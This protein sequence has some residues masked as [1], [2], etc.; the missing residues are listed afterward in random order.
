MLG[1]W[2]A[3]ASAQPVQTCDQSP[4]ITI[5]VTADD[6][7]RAAS[8]VRVDMF[9]ELP[10]T[11]RAGDQIIVSIPHQLKFPA[12]TSYDVMASD[13]S[14]MGVMRVGAEYVTVTWNSWIETHSLKAS[15][16]AFLSASVTDQVEKG[17]TSL[18][19]NVQGTVLRTPINVAVCETECTGMPDR[20]GKWASQY[21]TDTIN[22][23]LVSPT[24]LRPGTVITWTDTVE[25]GQEIQCDSVA[26]AWYASRDPKTGWLRHGGKISPTITQ[27]DGQHVSAT[28]SGT[29]V[30]KVYGL[31]LQIRI[32]DPHREYWRDH[33][34]VTMDSESQSLEAKAYR[35]DGGAAGTGSTPASPT[36][37]P[38]S[39]TGT[40]TIPPVADS[41]GDAT[42]APT[43]SAEATAPEATASAT[44]TGTSKAD[45]T[46][47]PSGT[48][49]QSPTTLPVNSHSRV[50]VA[51]ARL[52]DTGFET[53]DTA[54]LGAGL[55]VVGAGLVAGSRIRPRPAPA[56]RRPCGPA[57]D[58]AP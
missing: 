5:C 11:T 56:S 32:T 16:K 26:G 13:G 6:P 45:E 30:G 31:L 57:A 14:V 33:G 47:T 21:T 1:P 23:G 53:T 18:T 49:A 9:G 10:R 51:T 38:A 42:I 54:L 15:W 27:C 50:P 17:A 36:P 29:E 35:Y 41:K 19:W 28:F 7:A 52:A 22:A 58:P 39:P 48:M 44:G 40:A 34:T 4:Q 37:S 2:T 25:D 43:E 3:S 8:T 24:V 46:G 20:A 55:L 12:G